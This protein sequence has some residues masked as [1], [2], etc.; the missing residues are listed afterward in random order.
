M[1]GLKRETE[2]EKGEE[3]SEEKG[4]IATNDGKM[5]AKDLKIKNESKPSITSQ[6]DN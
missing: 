2:G 5:V 6:V 1:F 3:K 4:E